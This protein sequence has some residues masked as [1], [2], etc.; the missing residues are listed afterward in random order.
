MKRFFAMMGVICMLSDAMAQGQAKFDA[1]LEALLNIQYVVPETAGKFL[2]AWERLQKNSSPEQIETALRAILS[3]PSK[4]QQWLN[5]HKLAVRL[6]V[7]ESFLLSWERDLL[8]S[9]HFLDDSQSELSRQVMGHL[10]QHGGSNEARFLR[11][12]ADRLP[13]NLSSEKRGC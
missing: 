5:A 4:K 10:I 13:S 11:E 1:S 2:Y 6:P 9:R 8:Q 3:D 7:A 12:L